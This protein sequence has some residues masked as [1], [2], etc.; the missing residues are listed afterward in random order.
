MTTDCAV[1]PIPRSGSDASTTTAA[2]GVPET[3]LQT[4]R[5]SP[6]NARVFDL[7]VNEA[8]RSKRGGGF[9]RSVQQ[10]PPVYQ[11]AWHSPVFCGDGR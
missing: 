11:P 3:P 8:G 7:R 1:W 10:W 6:Q 9:N 4:G 5:L 2:E